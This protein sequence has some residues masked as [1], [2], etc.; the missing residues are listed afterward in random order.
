MNL[1]TQLAA[2]RNRSLTRTEHAQHCCG[3]AKD[4]EKAGEYEAACE[5]F[6][7]FWPQRTEPPIIEGLDRET[8][9]HVLLRV[10]ALAGWLGSAHQD[11][12]RQEAAKNFIT[13][14][15]E[16]FEELGLS[17]RVA[18][19]HADLALCYWRE[20]AFD[21]ARVHLAEALD[22][23][24][25]EN[26]DLKAC[27]LIRAGLVEVTA[28]RWNESLRL[29]EESAPLVDKSTDHAL[30]GT[31]HNSLGAVLSSLATADN[32]EDHLDRALIEYA[33][34]SFHFEQAG[35]TRYQASVENNLGFLFSTIGKFTEAHTHIDRARGL[36]ASLGDRGHVA[37]VDD[38]R[39]RTLLAEGRIVEAERYARS[40][41]KTLENG[42]ECSLLV[43]ALTTHG[44][45]LARLGNYKKSKALLQR[46]IKVAETC[47]DLE[48]AGRANL[49]I[50]EEL[51]DQTSATDL[52][53]NYK[54]A[55]D[56][57]QRS[58]DP[59]AT[60]RLLSCATKVI[61]ALG[62]VRDE[63]DAEAKEHS[64]EGF[65]FKQEI[66]KSEKALIERALR[67][68][69]GS[70][71]KAARL[72]GF[73]HHQ[74]LIA[75]IGTR[76][77]D[78]LKTRSIVRKRRRHIF[79]K[80]KK[81]E[82]KIVPEGSRPAASQISILQAE[83][84][85]MVASLLGDMFATQ[86]WWVERCADGGSALDKLTSGERYDLLLFD[87]DLPGLSGL[88]LVLRARSMPHR[89]RTPII[90]LSGNDCEAEAWR[91]GVDDFLRKPKG[92]DQV[93]SAIARLLKIA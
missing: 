81:A 83:D 63:E 86:H 27:V 78:L 65:S 72:L 43:E 16:I 25:N 62:A 64:W 26:T 39:A 54:S 47:G 10:G 20:G 31:F 56:L 1:A 45:A 82:G 32:R 21:E 53:S 4:L 8:T 67:D 28:G 50:I 79:S 30:K 24:K 75:L 11:E 17:Q 37:Q 14:S 41:V 13:Q 34:A 36:F 85:E 55:V 44:T 23:V 80:P 87:N 12:R 60:K 89:R 61:D 19:G 66:F 38:T 33:A 15:I 7:E 2:T 73:K 5:A 49:S 58:Q 48:G 29:Y 52:V 69:G 3:Q 6:V 88:E 74:S 51:S 9:A 76:H 68:A 46:A 90:M 57:L 71:T 91:A 70:V 42:D 92:I 77:K 93:L 35:N 40:A 84:N 59:S 22:R 18:E